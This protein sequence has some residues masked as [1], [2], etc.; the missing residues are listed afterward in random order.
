MRARSILGQVQREHGELTQETIDT[1]ALDAL[2]FLITEAL[3]NGVKPDVTHR[4]GLAIAELLEGYLAGG[5]D[6]VSMHGARAKSRM[7]RECPW[8]KAVVFDETATHCTQCTGPDGSPSRLTRR[9]PQTPHV[10]TTPNGS[11]LV[12]FGTVQGNAGTP[13]RKS[14]AERRGKLTRQKDGLEQWSSA[15][16]VHDPSRQR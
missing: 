16:K 3:M 2:N 9:P 5:N 14:F 7:N 11:R 12:Q 4:M 15:A 13:S 10:N 1:Y 6:L 8:C